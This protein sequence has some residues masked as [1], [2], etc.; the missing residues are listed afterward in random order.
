MQSRRRRGRAARLIVLALVVY[1]IAPLYGLQINGWEEYALQARKNQL[2]SLV[3]RA[4]RGTIYDRHGR[5]VAE[6][7]VGYHVLLMPAHRDSLRR[8]VDAL[9]PVLGL[10]SA[11]VATVF[12][13]H[14]RAPHL[15]MEVLRDAPPI[16]VARLQERIEEFPYVI[17]REYPKRHYPAGAAIAHFIGYVSEIS[18]AELKLPEFREYDQGRWIGKAGLERQYEQWLGGEPGMRFLEVD[19]GGRIHRWLPEALG[20][21]SVPGRDLHLYLDLDLQRYIASIFPKDRTGAIVAIEPSTGGILAYYSHPT[22]DPND[23]IGGIPTQT[24]RRL[25]EDPGK[26]LLDRVVSSG[27]PAASTWKLAVAAMALD[28]GAITPEEYMPIPC[29]GG[30][31]LAG[32]YARCWETR[33]HGRMNLIEGIRNSCNVYFYQVGIRIGFERFMQTGARLGFTERTGVD[34]PHEIRPNFPTERAYYEKRFGYRPL[35]NEVLSL[36]IGQGP[37]TMTTLKLAHVYSALARPDGRVPA[38]RLAMDETAWRAKRDTLHVK[39]D[40]FDV[41][42]LEAGMRRVVGPGGTAALSR[43]QN[44]DFFGK[45]GTAQNPHGRDH[46]WFVGMGARA[47]GAEPEIA[48][49]MFLE[50]AEHGYTASGYVAEAIDFYLSRRH[51]RPFRG[52]ATPR[53]RFAAGQPVDWNWGAPIVDPPKPPAPDVRA[54]P[55]AGSAS[56]TAARSSGTR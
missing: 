19:A 49:T 15:P 35:E 31:A 6:N 4:P 12:R 32:R 2:R 53:H 56:G 18:E 7:I 26:P 38:P 45:T 39:L 44:W 52:W 51:G 21:P 41:W 46:A 40:P 17:L 43:L 54:R 1:L 27:Q 3:M 33:G 14:A 48:V 5:V 29:T 11:A 22:Y 55:T 8:K 50:F 10:D 24:W 42:H 20:V 25:R 16:A 13:R 23:F 47:P 9:A 34:V 37:I 36:A 28:V 30:V